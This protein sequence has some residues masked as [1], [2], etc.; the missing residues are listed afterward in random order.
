[1]R[2]SPPLAGRLARLSGRVVRF[3]D[4]WTLDPH[5]ATT[6]RRSTSNTGAVFFVPCR[7]AYEP[8]PETRARC[9]M[10]ASAE[11]VWHE[12]GRVFWFVAY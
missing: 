12:L 3:L 6:V 7:S 11:G 8:W 2:L 10:R 4:R 5:W 1:M 9:P